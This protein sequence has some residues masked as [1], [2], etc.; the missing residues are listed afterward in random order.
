MNNYLPVNEGV[1]HINIY[2]KS[3]L[4]LGRMLSNFYY[5]P[6]CAEGEQFNSVEG[7]WFWLKTGRKYHFLKKLYGYN[8]KKQGETLEKVFIENFNE[9]ICSAI[10]TKVISNPLISKALEESALPLSHYYYYGD[11]SNPK[12]YQLPQYQWIVDKIES[13]R[14][15]LKI[16]SDYKLDI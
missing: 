2:S 1:D 12:M 5:S 16:R 7:Y 9:R 10:E 13:I 8:A 15:K 14:V 6:F 3:S 4:L 11:I